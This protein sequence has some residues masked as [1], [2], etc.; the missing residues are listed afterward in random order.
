MTRRRAQ[1]EQQIQKAII[2]HL[3][4][5]GQ[6]DCVFF[7]VP[8]GGARRRVEAAILKS[9]G[10]VAGVPDLLLFRGGH[11]YA[12]ELKAP[13]GR[14]S[15]AQLEMLARLDVAGVYTALCYGLDRA[16]AVL[17]AWHLLRG[18]TS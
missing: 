15:A 16:L 11:A 7:H 4:L 12:I 17:E 14:P 3:R 13:D 1:P 9:L 18:T 10:V 5:R 6:P 8:N 2:Q